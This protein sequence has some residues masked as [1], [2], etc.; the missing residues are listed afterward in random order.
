MILCRQLDN[1]IQ[2][3]GADHVLFGSGAPFKEI[4]PALI[5]LHHAQISSEAR[6]LIAGKNARQWFDL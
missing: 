5:K 3:V 6:E 2:L 1:F 4:E